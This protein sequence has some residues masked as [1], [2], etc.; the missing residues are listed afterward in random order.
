M[1]ILSAIAGGL[2]CVTCFLF[3]V[4]H[5]LACIFECA[6]SKTLSGS[7]KATWIVVSFFAGVFGSLAYALFASGSPKLRSITWTGMKLGTVNLLLAIGAFAATPDVREF[8]SNPL[9]ELSVET[10]NAIADSSLEPITVEEV[11]DPQTVPAQH[12]VAVVTDSL[13]SQTDGSTEDH[14]GLIEMLAEEGDIVPAAIEIPTIVSEPVDSLIAEAQ[15]EIVAADA[16]S[17]S[18][19]VADY[20][21]LAEAFNDESPSDA[22]ETTAAT[23]DTQT[24]ALSVLEPGQPTEVASAIESTSNAVLE[25]ENLVEAVIESVDPADTGLIPEITG[26]TS[27]I[28][29]LTSEST[30]LTSE[31][32]VDATLESA[33]GVDTRQSENTA[34]TPVVTSPVEATLPVTRPAEPPKSDIVLPHAEQRDVQPVTLAKPETTLKKNRINRYR[35]EGY[36]VYEVTVPQTPTVRNRY[37]NQ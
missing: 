35:V 32:T 24:L 36:P 30:G 21:F 19:P 12:Y 14:A 34:N 13:E 33:S 37:T 17:S 15:T 16:L 5:P 26:L 28:T 22:S 27:E 23:E 9:G 11:A 31:S 1:L 4:V 6:Y 3:L 10:T 20:Q 29:G 18:E 2:L 7:Q 25:P 8:F